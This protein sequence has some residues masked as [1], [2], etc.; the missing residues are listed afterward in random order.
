MYPWLLNQYKILGNS[1][2]KLRYT[3]LR[4]DVDTLDFRDKIL[5][6]DIDTIRS[7]DTIF[8]SNMDRV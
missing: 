1:I 5:G 6:S 2:E 4:S 3:I 7:R 8:G